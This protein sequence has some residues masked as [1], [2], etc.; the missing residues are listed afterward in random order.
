[1]AVFVGLC[2]AAIAGFLVGQDAAKRGMS[3]WGWGLFVFLILIIGLPVYLI[4]KKP[5]LNATVDPYQTVTSSSLKKCPYC[6]ELIQHDAIKCKYCM[7]DL[8]KGIS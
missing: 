3:A 1:M 2:I 5:Y 8:T 4:A 7:S 6:A